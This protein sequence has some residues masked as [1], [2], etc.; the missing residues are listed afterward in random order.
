MS[1]E[2]K[3]TIWQ[4]L[5]A[6]LA[7]YVLVVAR[8]GYEYGRND[9]TQVLCYAKYLNNPDL[10]PNDY[11]IQN[12]STKV[13]NER[14]VFSW[15]LSGLG[16]W[17]QPLAFVLHI[18]FS[19]A[20]FFLVYKI[21]K[22]FIE[23]DYLI[24]LGILVLNIFFQG[25]NLGS[26]E[27][28][29]NTFFVSIVVTTLCL[30]SIY[31]YLKNDNYWPSFLLFG[32]ATWLQ[33]VFGTQLFATFF[34]ITL[35]GKWLNQ[36]E[37]SW[38]TIAFCFFSWILT[39]GVW[40]LYLKFFFEE[41]GVSNAL[42]YEILFDFR[43]PH[44]YRPFAFP[45]LSYLILVPA[46]FISFLFYIKNK[47]KLALFFGITFIGLILATIFV[48][49][50]REVNVT[51]LQWFKLTIWL[52]LFSMIAIVA[53]LENYFPFLKNEN[54]K[55]AAYPVLLGAG[56]VVVSIFIYNPKI[57][58]WNVPFDFNAGARND[59][60]VQISKMAREKT[61][62]DATFI[63]PIA[64]TELKYYGERS[65]YLDFKILVHRKQKMV[66]W[67]RRMKLIYGLDND[68]KQKGLNANDLADDYFTGL[69]EAALA[70]LKEREGITHILTF[71]NHQL[72]L[73]VIA[74]NNRYKIYLIQ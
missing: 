66:E 6:L 15:L 9:Q 28:W 21:A 54:L 42:F 39:G 26:N 11:Y 23:S 45:L 51:S 72:S 48:E 20:L 4:V 14:F 19:L 43:S 1:V 58:F 10:Y 73:P 46:F 61:P 25:I 49:G 63:Y 29:T 22:E 59:P 64:F 52:K 24:W 16:D 27:L 53:L 50:F 67:Y 2:K 31:L 55:R 18:L 62:L 17:M 33:P 32:I 56:I 47:I 35:L 5:L 13:P 41:P 74:E 70:N 3:Y 71:T 57:F 34:G 60:A 44:H 37:V 12:L 40:V 68:S 7:C 38:K 65:S 69:N 8:W 36:F 30:F